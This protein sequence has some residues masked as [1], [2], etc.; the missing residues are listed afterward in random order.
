MLVPAI[1]TC[2]EGKCEAEPERDISAH[3]EDGEDIVV[4]R[5]DVAVA[6]E[7]GHGDGVCVK[8]GQV[9]AVA[10][11]NDPDTAVPGRKPPGENGNEGGGED[12]LRGLEI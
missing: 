8:H 4:L 5:A 6:A 1:W 2:E 9:V 12:D 3:L 11:V 10:A 7:G